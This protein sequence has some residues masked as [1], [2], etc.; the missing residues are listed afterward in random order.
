M[1]DELENSHTQCLTENVEEED[2]RKKMVLL[3]Q[4]SVIHYSEPACLYIG[5]YKGIKWRVHGEKNVNVHV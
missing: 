2:E 1:M 5:I 3:K 4:N